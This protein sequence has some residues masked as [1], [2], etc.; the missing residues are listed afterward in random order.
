MT[1][2]SGSTA[3]FSAVNVGTWDIGVT[4]LSGTTVVGTGSLSGQV[5]TGGTTNS[6]TV[7]ISDT[8]TGTGNFSFTFAFPS[9]TSINYVAAQLY[10][11]SSGTAVGS[12]IVPT[13]T[14]NGTNQQGTVAQTG[15]ASGSYRLQMT[16]YRGGASGTVAGIYGESVDVWDNVTSDQWLDSSG[17]LNS[18]RTFVTTDFNSANT[19]LSNLVVSSGGTALT[20]SPGFSSNVTTYTTAASS[21]VTITPTAS[22]AGQAIQYQMNGTSGTWTT[23]GSGVTSAA[24]TLGTTSTVIYVKVTANDQISTTTYQI[25]VGQTYTLTPGTLSN[26]SMTPTSA[27]TVTAGVAT[28]ITATPALGYVF[29]GWTA[30][31]STNATFTSSTSA[32][33]T[34]ILTGNVTI[35]P[36]FVNVTSTSIPMVLIPAGSF[37]N[38]TSVVTLSAFH[39]AAYDITQSQYKAITGTNPSY[40]SSNSDAATCPV[41]QVTW[42]DAVE[43]CNKLSTAG[44]LTAVYTITG[45]TPATGY[46]ITSATVTADFTQNGYRLPTEAQWEYACRAGTATTYFWGNTSGDPDTTTESYAWYASNS[47]STTHG[48][49]QKLP[50]PWGLY[51]IVGDV[52]Q[53]CWDWYGTYPSGTQTNPT[54]PSSGTCRVGRGGSWGDSSGYLASAFRG[55]DSPSRGDYCIGFRVCAP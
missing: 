27:Q 23:I 36:T 3:S 6:L 8:Q 11:A 48:V 51:D 50:N 47:N 28:S 54:G 43:F 22:V 44:G 16:F 21:T 39:M 10:N 40:F 26:G 53:W 52:W 45:R 42:F 15:I 38:G 34:V 20:L 12:T 35:T 19:N 30:S 37:N 17:N 33:T 18:Q 55:D 24:L 46:P 7:S 1:V 5:I 31:P 9:S 29:S 32:S 14:T 25:T 49:G 4:A 2:T 13:L 41:E